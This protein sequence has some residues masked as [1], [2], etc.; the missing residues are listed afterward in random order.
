MR[1]FGDYEAAADRARRRARRA[2]GRARTEGGLYLAG[3]LEGAEPIYRAQLGR[4]RRGRRTRLSLDLGGLLALALLE[5]GR[6]REAEAILDEAEALGAR[7]RLADGGLRRRCACAAR[8]RSTAAMTKRSLPRGHA[9]ELGDAGY[10]MLRPWFT[11]EHGRALA[12]AGRDDEARRVLE[13]AIRLARVKGSTVFEHRAQDLL[14][15]L[16]GRPTGDRRT[17]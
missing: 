15:T 1:L 12:A 10:F 16:T 14:D 4:P 17:V 7:G 5:L 2:H 13:E 3:D 11:T 9:A 6:R 8:G